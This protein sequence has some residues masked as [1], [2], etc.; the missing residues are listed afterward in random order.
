VNTTEEQYVVAE[1]EGPGL[2][3]F[4]HRT[5]PTFNVLKRYLILLLLVLL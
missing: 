1:S 2:M 4:D 5:L 3:C